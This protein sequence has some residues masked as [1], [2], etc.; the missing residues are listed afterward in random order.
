[1]YVPNRFLRRM[2]GRQFKTRPPGR[3]LYGKQKSA[4]SLVNCCAYEKVLAHEETFWQAY[5]RRRR[6][7]YPRPSNFLSPLPLLWSPKKTVSRNRRGFTSI[8]LGRRLRCAMWQLKDPVDMPHLRHNAVCL[9][10]QHFPNAVN[11]PEWADSVLI[12]PGGVYKERARHVFTVSA[13]TEK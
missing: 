2:T 10:T 13:L 9:E 4:R 11:Q 7:T 6:F 1:M 3:Q 8:H 5:P 12:P